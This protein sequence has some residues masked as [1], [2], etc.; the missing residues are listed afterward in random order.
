M[1]AI[2]DYLLT[3]IVLKSKIPQ[4]NDTYNCA[5]Y[6]LKYALETLAGRCPDRDGWTFTGEDAAR[7]R[8]AMALRLVHELNIQ[9]NEAIPNTEQGQGA[10]A[11]TSRCE[12]SSTR[13]AMVSERPGGKSARPGESASGMTVPSLSTGQAT[14]T[15]GEEEITEGTGPSTTP[16]STDRQ[17]VWAVSQ[18]K[19]ESKQTDE[20][21][22]MYPSYDDMSLY[23]AVT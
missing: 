17:G 13:P 2:R 10:Q 12:E 8:R 1:R 16:T 21:A 19:S 15:P 14:A 22:D 5:A 18:A 6:T 11:V 4:Q 23:M 9:D 3:T 7:L 20:G